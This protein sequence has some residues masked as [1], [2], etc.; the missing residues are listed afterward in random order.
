MG[1]KG[2]NTSSSCSCRQTRLWTDCV[3]AQADLNLCWTHMI[4]LVLL[5]P[6]SYELCLRH[7]F[8]TAA[9]LNE[10]H[11]K[12]RQ[13]GFISSVIFRHLMR[14]NV[15]KHAVIPMNAVFSFY[16]LVNTEICNLTL[17]NIR[18]EISEFTRSTFTGQG[19]S[20]WGNG[21]Q[22][23]HFRRWIVT[24]TVQSFVLSQCRT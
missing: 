4:L 11:Q 3:D 1:R 20:L 12:M 7:Q 15:T 8:A 24:F 19:F 16:I 6:G 10:H 22:H 14:N 17:Y 18:L 2:P 9:W 13:K 23:C 5:C 21:F